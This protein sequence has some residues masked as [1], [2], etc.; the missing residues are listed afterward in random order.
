LPAGQAQTSAAQQVVSSWSN[1]DPAGA[2]Q[3]VVGFPEGSQRDNA[4]QALSRNWA[5]NDPFGAADW[6][7]TLAP[8]S[9]REAAV[10]AYV[11]AVTYQ[12]PEAAVQWAQ[13]L[14]NDPNQRR[15]ENAARRWLV[16]DPARASEW[17]KTSSLP[18]KTQQKLLERAN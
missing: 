2:A 14:A 17:L 15:L 11:D 13:T 16:E 8:G 9:T 10:G 6:L 5:N 12:Y 3:W 4:V 7:A 18:A 1:S